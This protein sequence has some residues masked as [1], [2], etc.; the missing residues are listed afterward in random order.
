MRPPTPLV[1]AALAAFAGSLVLFG[2]VVYDL[3]SRGAP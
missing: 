3:M 2:L 1:L